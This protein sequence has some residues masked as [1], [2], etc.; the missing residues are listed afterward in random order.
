YY[1]QDDNSTNTDTIGEMV[2][3]QMADIVAIQNLYGAAG[4]SSETAGD[5]TWGANTTLTDS[6]LY[7]IFGVLEGRNSPDRDPA[8]S[9]TLTIYDVSG[10]DTID[11]SNN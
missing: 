4:E 11:L 6:Y 1:D 10:T 2:T 3:T 5:T 9:M 7:D 8:N